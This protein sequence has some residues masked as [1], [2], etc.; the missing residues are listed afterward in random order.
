M[1]NIRTALRRGLESVPG[2]G[3]AMLSI[4]RKLKL[5]QRHLQ[6]RFASGEDGLPDPDVVYWIDPQRVRL[7]TNHAPAGAATPPADRVFDPEADRG[8]IRD[9]DWDISDFEFRQLDVYQALEDVMLRKLPWEQTAFYQSLAAGMDGGTNPWSIHNSEA[10]VARCAYLDSLIQS[11]RTQG[12][13]L[14]HEVSLPGEVA[15][16]DKDERF[17]SEISVNV[18]RDGLYLFQD[19]RHR[20]AIAQILGLDK[21]PV[22]VLVRHRQWMVFRNYLQ[23][24]ATSCSGASDRP[25][26]YQRPCHPDLGDIPSAHGCED[27]LEAIGQHIGPAEP[28]RGRALDIGANLGFFCHGLEDLG[29]DCVAIEHQPQIAAAAE[30]IRDAERKSF[31]IV[32]EDLFVA[33]EKEGLAEVDFDIVLALNIFHHFLKD[34][35]THEHLRQWLGRMRISQMFFEPHRADEVQMQGAYRNYDE[36]AFVEFLLQNSQLDHASMIHACDD[37]RNLYRLWR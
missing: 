18:G 32:S 26:L 14:A 16:V 19:G 5:V 4:Y 30:K 31:R 11:M 7:H 37:G 10:L 22:K 9:G 1:S 27:R 36:Q 8:G 33:T 24:L 13:R 15:G 12:F 20:L 6:S 17:G 25:V 2:V 28:S 35:A 21:V 23:S 3:G 34:P 29:F